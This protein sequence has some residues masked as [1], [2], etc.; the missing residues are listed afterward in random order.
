MISRSNEQLQQESEYTLLKPDCHSWEDMA[1][2]VAISS[3]WIKHAFKTHLVKRL[4]ICCDKI[5]CL[6]IKLEKSELDTLK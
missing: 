1:L 2:E 5:L 3:V 6:L 4:H